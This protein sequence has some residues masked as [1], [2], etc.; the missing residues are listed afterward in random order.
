MDQLRRSL[1]I[2]KT[3]QRTL[4]PQPGMP[5]SQRKEWGLVL[6]SE[7]VLP[8]M[9]QF[10]VVFS[11]FALAAEWFGKGSVFDNQLRTAFW[12]A[13]IALCSALY[14]CRLLH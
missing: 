11:C 3:Y 9:N 6:H 10:P 14:I 7:Y 1:W 12:F 8:L 4:F 13:T 5:W 2:A